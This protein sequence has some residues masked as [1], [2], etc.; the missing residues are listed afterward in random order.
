MTIVPRTVF[1]KK[2]KNKKKKKTKQKKKNTVLILFQIKKTKYL[3]NL[4]SEYPNI[5]IRQFTNVRERLKGFPVEDLWIKN[6]EFEN[7][8]HYFEQISDVIRVVLLYEFGGLYL[9]L[10]LITMRRLP[11][12]IPSNFAV[13]IF[14]GNVA[15]AV[16]KFSKGHPILLH[17]MRL[18][19]SNRIFCGLIR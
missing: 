16:M 11:P 15:N 4:L 7:G 9:D 18:M 19:V 17:Y 3:Y 12:I 13:G 10:D 1:F 5:I 6:P 14:H 2:K 8:P